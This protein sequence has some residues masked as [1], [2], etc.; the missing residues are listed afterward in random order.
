MGNNRRHSVNI[1]RMNEIQDI[2]RA[3][4]LCAFTYE[5]AIEGK[6]TNQPIC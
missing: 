4:Y 1:C 6:L 5:E 3:R 2:L